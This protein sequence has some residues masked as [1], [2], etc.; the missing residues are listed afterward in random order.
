MGA[1]MNAI[2]SILIALLG[3]DRAVDYIITM[4]EKLKTDPKN[5]VDDEYVELQA[6]SL[7]ER[8]I[9]N[10]KPSDGNIMLE[11]DDIEKIKKTHRRGKK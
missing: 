9:D 11:Q 1:V 5:A 3:S 6:K 7:K 10:K 4:I 8:V 2:A